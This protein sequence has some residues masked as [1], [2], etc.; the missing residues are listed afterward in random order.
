[1]IDLYHLTRTFK[2]FG[3]LNRAF[4]EEIGDKHFV[5]ASSA[6]YRR[7]VNTHVCDT[8]REAILNRD[9]INKQLRK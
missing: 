9:A 5:Y 7:N 6:K 1:M 2:T 8:K 3:N 4:I